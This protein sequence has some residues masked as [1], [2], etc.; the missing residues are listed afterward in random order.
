MEE[1]KN[2]EIQEDEQLNH[3]QQENENQPSEEKKDLPQDDK[4]EE[5]SEEDK[6]N[7]RHKGRHAQAK[8]LEEQKAKYAELNVRELPQTHRQRETRHDR[9]SI[10]RRHQGHAARH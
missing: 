9:H 3:P 10:G 2:I 7:R 8:A 4:K 1:K 6:E 5:K